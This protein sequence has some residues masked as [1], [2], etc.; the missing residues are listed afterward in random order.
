MADYVHCEAGKK[1]LDFANPFGLTIRGRAGT[2]REGVTNAK[3]GV[4]RDY[5]FHAR[6]L[7]VAHHAAA[8]EVRVSVASSAHARALA[9]RAIGAGFA[10]VLRR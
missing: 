6:L 4:V 1:P 2:R 10:G 3:V 9:L 5:S 7:A 8:L